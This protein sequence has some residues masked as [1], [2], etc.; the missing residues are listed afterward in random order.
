MELGATLIALWAAQIFSGDM[1][2]AS[3]ALGW[4]LLTLAVCDAMSFR[5]PDALTLPLVLL[6]L[7]GTWCLAPQTMLDHALAAALG[8]L[9]FRGIA[10][11]YRRLRGREGLG[12]GDAKLMAAAGAWLGLAALP[13]VLL[14]AALLG[15]AFAGLQALRGHVVSHRMR[16]PFGP[17]LAISTWL[18][19]LYF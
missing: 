5:L 9:S 2:W 17:C 7:G 3:C 11:L 1:L 8:Y 10:S 12:Q 19:W 13:N 18:I 6:G 4:M 16:L 15:L 14:G